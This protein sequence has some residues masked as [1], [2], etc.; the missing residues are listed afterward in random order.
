M[1]RSLTGYSAFSNAATLT[2]SAVTRVFF[3]VLAVLCCSFASGAFG[4]EH[5]SASPS[6]QSRSTAIIWSELLQ[7]KPFPYIAPLPPSARTA[8]DGTYTK[9]DPKETPPVPCRRCPDYAPEGGIWKLNLDQ[10]VFRI[11]HETAGWRSLGSFVVDGN[12]VQ[13]FNDPCCIEVRG[14]YRWSIAEGRLMLQ[15]VEDPCAIGLRAKNLTQ[16]PWLSCETFS[17]DVAAGNHRL[18]PPG[19]E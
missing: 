17:G 18:K 10:G 13:L 14:F 11:F 2:F 7:K 4:Q 1:N 12:R 6:G 3:G 19:C 16:L 15:A 5:A 9:F 8:L